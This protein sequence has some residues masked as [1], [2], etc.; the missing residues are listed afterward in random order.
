MNTFKKN[1]YTKSER[2]CIKKQKENAERNMG[3]K[4]GP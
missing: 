4:L 1:I 3:I 2:F